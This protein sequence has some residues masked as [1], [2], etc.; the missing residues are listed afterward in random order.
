MSCYRVLKSEELIQP[1]FIGHD[2]RQAAEQRRQRLQ[3]PDKVNQL[4]QVDVT[5]HVTE[6]YGK[7]CIG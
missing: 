6:G 4:S 3:A 7:H 5:D 2:L 1:K